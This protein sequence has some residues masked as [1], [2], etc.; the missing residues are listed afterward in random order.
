MNKTVTEAT[1]AV[2]GILALSIVGAVTFG[3][4]WMFLGYLRFYG[5]EPG[6]VARAIPLELID[7]GNSFLNMIAAAIDRYN[8]SF[9]GN[10]RFGS[11]IGMIAA[12]CCSLLLFKNKPVQVKVVAAFLAGAIVGGRFC[13]TFTSSPA[14]FLVSALFVALV[15]AAVQ[16]LAQ[17]KL[18]PLPTIDFWQ[19]KTTEGNQT[20]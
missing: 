8:V 11:G 14:P 19:S 12:A 16:K 6:V 13:L 18:P 1:R 17:Q 5:L 20:L 9:Q 2:A 3:Y 4:L 7:Y 10:A 15:F